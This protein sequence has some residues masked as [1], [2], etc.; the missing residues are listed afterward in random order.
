[1]C[2]SY[3]KRQE[4]DAPP[5][6]QHLTI[7]IKPCFSLQN[8]CLLLL[9]NLYTTVNLPLTFNSFR[10]ETIIFLKKLVKEKRVNQITERWSS[11]QLIW[12]LNSTIVISLFS[13]LIRRSTSADGEDL[14]CVL[15]KKNVIVKLIEFFFISGKQLPHR[16]T[17][18]RILSEPVLSF[19]IPSC[20]TAFI[21]N[22]ICLI[23]QK[24]N[25]THDCMLL[26]YH[27]R[28]VTKIFTL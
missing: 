12:Y 23:I 3:C 18:S 19:R 1:M 11:S 8:V 14:F 24:I 22:R 17:F 4:L 9:F 13:Q 6:P 2:Q 21:S 26:S 15:H 16:R 25:H 10:E 5:L 28:V 7:Q 27:V 20:A